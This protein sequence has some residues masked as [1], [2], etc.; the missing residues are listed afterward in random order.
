MT[1][2]TLSLR[3]ILGSARAKGCMRIDLQNMEINHLPQ[4]PGLITYSMLE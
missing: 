4:L 2:T 1:G 3:I